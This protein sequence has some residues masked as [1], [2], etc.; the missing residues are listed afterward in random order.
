MRPIFESCSVKMVTGSS[1]GLCYDV[2]FWLQK[3][4]HNR[5][6]ICISPKTIRR[7]LAAAGQETSDQYGDAK[8]LQECL[9]NTYGGDRTMTSIATG[10]VNK[11]AA[12]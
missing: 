10:G 6:K 1:D 4:K 8:K 2:M 3:Q 7:N 9:D 11:A 12:A 5:S